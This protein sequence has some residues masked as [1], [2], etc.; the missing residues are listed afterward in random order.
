MTSFAEPQD[1]VAVWRPFVGN[2]QAIA[3]GRLEHASAIIRQEIPS[4]DERIASGALDAVLVKFVVIDM[5]LRHLRNR[6]GILSETAGAWSYRRDGS[7]AGGVVYLDAE[8]RRQLSGG[9]SGARA[10]S[11][12][13]PLGLGF[14]NSGYC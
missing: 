10:R 3:T 2:E 12:R 5:V 1:V 14:A 11:L 7:L 9:R 8:Q 4:I 6:D 13:T